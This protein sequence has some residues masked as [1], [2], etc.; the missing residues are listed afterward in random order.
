[1]WRGPRASGVADV[2]FEWLPAT[3]EFTR[4]SVRMTG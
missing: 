3:G 2:R 1:M 4:F